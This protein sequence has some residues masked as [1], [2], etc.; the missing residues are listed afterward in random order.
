[1]STNNKA[2]SSTVASHAGRVLSDPTASET[3]KSLAAS[4]LSQHSSKHQTGAAMED[5]A[6]RVLDSSKYSDGT[7]SLAGSV[8]SQANKAR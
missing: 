8:L 4:A 3:A 1:M 2:T 6:A 5:L 7:K